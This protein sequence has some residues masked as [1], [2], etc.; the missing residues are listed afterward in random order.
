MYLYSLDLLSV[1]H[2][3]GLINEQVRTPIVVHSQMY[4]G[5]S[6][7]VWNNYGHPSAFGLVILCKFLYVHAQWT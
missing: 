3:W 4:M 6:K 7:K 5:A 2:M 1:A